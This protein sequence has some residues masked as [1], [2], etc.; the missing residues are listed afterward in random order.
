MAI[1]FH[2]S[3]DLV[4]RLRGGGRPIVFLVGS[5]LTMPTAQGGPGVCNV[6][7]MLELIRARVATPKGTGPGDRRAAKRAAAALDTKLA[8]VGVGGSRYQLA[9]E[10]LK[11]LVDGAASVN[12]VIREAV[13]K[14]RTVLTSV[15]MND[16]HALAQLE[17]SAHGWHLGPGVKALGLLVA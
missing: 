15:D 1:T 6:E 16:V 4:Q 3:D 14:A 7:A 11:A 10:Q 12:L 5:A 8:Q 2:S 13:L 9:F 17:Q